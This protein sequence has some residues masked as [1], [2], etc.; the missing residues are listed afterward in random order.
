MKLWVIGKPGAD[1][2]SQKLVAEGF[3]LDAT[4]PDFILVWGGDG[5]IL[6]AARRYPAI[7]L[8]GLRVD[9]IGRLAEVNGQDWKFAIDKL[10]QREYTI[11]KA[12]HIEL[13]STEFHVHGVNEVYFFREYEHA[14]RMKVLIDDQDVYGGDLF[15]DGCL[16]ATPRG[17]TA[18]SW[19]TGRKIALS[20]QENAFVFTPLSS[21]Y[22]NQLTMKNGSQ[23]ARIADQFRV[24]D[25]QKVTI[26]IIRGGRNKVATDGLDHLKRYVSL[27]QGDRLIFQKAKSHTLFVRFKPSH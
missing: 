15:G 6:Q 1:V 4:H 2:L 19:T 17:S 26:E 16:A 21:G 22:M 5:S 13:T 12:P 25:H 8:L 11:E 18:Y 9:S 3:D 14:T 20:P 23:V 7:P 27:Q 24:A 10:Q